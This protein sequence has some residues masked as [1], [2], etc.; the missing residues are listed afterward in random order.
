[1]KILTIGRDGTDIVLKDKSKE[2][3]RLHAE[4]TIADDGSY[5]LVDCG[6]SNGT[7][8]RRHDV[9][10]PIKQEYVRADD[11]IRFG[12]SYTTSIR[13]LLGKLLPTAGTR[14]P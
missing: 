11:Q 13:E 3:S 14:M 10:K 4:L 9:W 2:I 8:V 6:S 12:A 1:M 7:S 5:Y